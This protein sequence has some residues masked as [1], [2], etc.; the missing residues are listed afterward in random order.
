VSGL[1]DLSEYSG[2]AY[3][4][5]KYNADAGQSGIFYLDDILV[6]SE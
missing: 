6:Y 2:N 5:F 4:A 1:V 3:I